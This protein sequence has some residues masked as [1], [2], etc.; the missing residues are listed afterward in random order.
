MTV[1][2]VLRP[3]QGTPDVHAEFLALYPVVQRHAQVVFRGRS[4]TDREEATAEAVAAAFES[5]VRLKERGKN[6]AQDF[7]SSMANMAALHVK[8]DRHV[9]GRSSSKDVLSRKA[10]Q[11]HGF[12]VEALPVSPRT[13]WETRSAGARG[14][15]KQAAWEE[16]LRDNTRTPVPDQ[17]AFRLDFPAFLRTLSGRDRRLARF[18]ARG[19]SGTEAAALFQLSPGRVTQLRQRWQR[20]WRVFKGETLEGQAGPRADAARA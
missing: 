17:V 11:T 4:V 20:A 3:P 8:D 7:P 2:S 6:P 16:G 1:L 15:P 9:G 13:S 5:F 19:R 14:Q 12:S 18:L 10:Q